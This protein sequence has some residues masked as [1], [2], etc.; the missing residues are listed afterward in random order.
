MLDYRWNLVVMGVCGVGKSVIGRPLSNQLGF[1]FVEGDEYHPQENVD[2]M[3]AGH[4]LDDDDRWPWLRALREFSERQNRQA[5]STVIAC[6]A[7]KRSYREILR[8]GLPGTRFIHLSGDKELLL[9][10]MRGRDHFMPPEMLESQL[11]TLE[12]LEPDEQGVVVSVT[13]PVDLIVKDLML[14][15][16]RQEGVC[17][18]DTQEGRCRGLR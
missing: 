9:D 18:M 1:E 15:L 2:K 7:L 3:S 16:K 11:D 6:S 10:R 5:K 17:A 8:D 14:R 12:P 13:D 4:P